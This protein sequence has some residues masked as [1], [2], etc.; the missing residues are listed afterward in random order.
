MSLLF[1]SVPKASRP[2][3]IAHAPFIGANR[4]APLDFTHPRIISDTV[5][6]FAL[7]E[8]ETRY[9]PLLP[10]L[11]FLSPNNRAARNFHP[12]L[13][14]SPFPPPVPL[15]AGKRNGNAIKSCNRGSMGRDP[16]C[17][18]K[19][20]GTFSPRHRDF[21]LYS[22]TRETSPPLRPTRFLNKRWNLKSESSTV[23]RTP[24]LVSSFVHFFRVT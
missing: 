12:S 9:S 24:A 2:C 14:L 19:T 3:E 8:T 23:E 5:F 18:G 7:K 16:F 22:R 17:Q 21:S 13:Q 10:H 1:P 11:V 15:F 20:R 4:A 6:F